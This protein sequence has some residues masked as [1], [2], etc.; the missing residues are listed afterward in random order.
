MQMVKGGVHK[1]KLE[2]D[3]AV[4]ELRAHESDQ[5]S[6]GA[7]P[8]QRRRAGGEGRQPS[9]GFMFFGYPALRR[10]IQIMHTHPF[11]RFVHYGKNGPGRKPWTE[12][13]KPLY[14]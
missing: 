7:S 14:F 6:H 1:R 8:M 4:S 12:Y 11:E 2:T 9:L 10:G 13:P 3:T 5:V